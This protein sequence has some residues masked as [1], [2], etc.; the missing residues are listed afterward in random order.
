MPPAGTPPPRPVRH[1]AARRDDPAI[2]RATTPEPARARLITR[3]DD[4]LVQVHVRGARCDE[5][6]DLG[7]VL[8][9]ERRDALVHLVGTL[10]IALEPHERELGFDGA[11]GDLGQ[12]HRFAE[13]LTA[14]RPVHHRL[15]ML[16]GGITGAVVVRLERR[17]RRRSGRPSGARRTGD[18]PRARVVRGCRP[19]ARGHRRATWRPRHRRLRPPSHGHPCRDR[20]P[21][22]AV[23]R[24]TALDRA[25]AAD[26]PPHGGYARAARGCARHRRRGRRRRHLGRARSRHDDRERR[27]VG[28]RR[29]PAHGTCG[30]RARR[31]R[32]ALVTASVLVSPVWRASS[33]AS[34]S[35]SGLRML[36]AIATR[37]DD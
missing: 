10:L 9:D 29:G 18:R 34:R 33:A 22:R 8:C 14:Q 21:A 24:S 26:L 16:G 37:V 2:D 30:R 6:D 7:D 13:Q 28:A 25:R 5:P 20:C 31:S 1:G 15:G 19:S 27:G 35:A 11:G 32:R 23:S 4:D 12:P 3:L 36:R 17:D